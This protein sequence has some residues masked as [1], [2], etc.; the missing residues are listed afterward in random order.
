MTVEAVTGSQR[1]RA[2]WQ[3][4]T[5][6]SAA[7]TDSEMRHRA[8]LLAG[9]ALVLGALATALNLVNFAI[10]P[11]PNPAITSVLG[12]GILSL[13]VFVYALA[14]TSLYLHGAA[15]AVFVFTV[16][17]LIEFALIGEE[18]LNLIYYL[19]IPLALC[20]LVFSL[21]LA[22]VL[23][24]VI[25]LATALIAVVY[26]I[27]VYELTSNA[28]GFLLLITVMLLSVRRYLDEREQERRAQLAESEQRY[29]LVTEMI[30]DHAY[31][32]ARQ[33]GQWRMAWA[34]S[35]F[36]MLAG[37]ANK[38]LETHGWDIM[39]HPDDMPVTAARLADLESGLETACEFR[40]VTRD[41]NVR[42]LS[43]HARPVFDESG[44]VVQIVG[45]AADITARKS[46]EHAERE[47]RALAEALRA[48]A[49]S[50]AQSLDLDEVLDHL[51]ASLGR[52]V[53]YD[54]ASIMLIEDGV[55]SVVRHQG[56]KYT[57]LQAFLDTHRFPV[58]AT[59]SLREVYERGRVILIADTGAYPGW[60]RQPMTDW[61]R[62]WMGAP[63]RVGDEVIGFL[64]LDSSEPGHFTSQH[65]DRLQAFADQCS[66]AIRNARLYRTV[67]E[68]TAELERRVAARTAE[69]EQERRE[70]TA[71]LDSMG[72]GMC[73][74]E[75]GCIRYANRALLEMTGFAPVDLID[76]PL[77]TLVEDAADRARAGDLEA[78]LHENRVWR[79]ELLVHTRTGTLLEVGVTVAPLSAADTNGVFAPGAVAIVRDISLEKALQRQKNRFISTASHE[80]RTPITN[81]NTRL[82]L[83][84]RDPAR[85]DEHLAVLAEVVNR[86]R[87][88]SDD[89]LDLARLE[90]GAIALEIRPALL[91]D[92]VTGVVRVQQ[93]EAD[94]KNV[95]L[96]VCLPPAPLIVSVDAD[97]IAQVLTNLVVNAIAYTPAGGRVLVEVAPDDGWAVIRVSDTGVGIAPEYLM[98]VFEPFFRAAG[99]T[100]R[101]TGLGLSIAR[102]VVQLHGGEISVT[103]E[104]GRGSCFTVRLR[105]ADTG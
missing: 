38:E 36:G 8:R 39:V 60:M 24:I 68:Q 98:Q 53:P 88:L 25:T 55:A 2:L 37:Y 90:H 40:I 84:Q 63:I 34:S 21:R 20:L 3:R 52:V 58:E 14:R 32:F 4:L 17:I 81:L 28:L 7:I 61:I 19:F 64:N 75:G 71:I 41:G 51:L 47:Q 46:A 42:W 91:Q 97:R 101:G 45:A 100:V 74:I 48:A 77:S 76:M 59:A 5:E 35:D 67:R 62:S 93:A 95:A 30:T 65:A 73:Y 85:M 78:A 79:D 83:I 11:L 33:R 86:M 16:G 99:A 49:A 43:D 87:C 13:A 56:F 10:N 29:R 82:Y 26:G 103:S 50:V 54:A 23:L 27:P 89:L 69:L 31:C 22:L 15:L 57:D 70:L 104:Q 6:P 44:Q 96:D 102:E 18:A 12:A 1:L 92:L 105:T 80:L 66:A 9:L 94:L 72:E